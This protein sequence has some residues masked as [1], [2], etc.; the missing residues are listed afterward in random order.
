MHFVKNKKT[1][2][3]LSRMFQQIGK[4]IPGTMAHVCQITTRAKNRHKRKQRQQGNE[5]PDN[6]ISF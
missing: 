3:H 6:F 2:Q 5:C 1:N 4:C